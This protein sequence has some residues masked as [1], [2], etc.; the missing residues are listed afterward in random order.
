[1][2]ELWCF[3]ETSTSLSSILFARVWN[4]LALSVPVKSFAVKIPLFA[5]VNIA[6]LTKKQCYS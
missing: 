1:M 2:D 5:V 6:V 4:M 3:N